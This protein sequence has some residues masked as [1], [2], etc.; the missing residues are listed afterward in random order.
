MENSKTMKWVML[1]AFALV[2]IGGLNW[3]FVGVAMID[4]VALIFG[5]AASAG[6]R[7]IYT[8]VGLSAVCLLVMTIMK[9]S[10]AAKKTKK[11]T[12]KSE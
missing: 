7:I 1:V 4:V 8:L 2:I 12:T 5:G 10:T 9:S 11:S 6:S 3:L